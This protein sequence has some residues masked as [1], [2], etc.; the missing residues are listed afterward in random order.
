MEMI[1]A[2][3]HPPSILYRLP[4]MRMSPWLNLSHPTI[5]SGLMMCFSPLNASLSL[6]QLMFKNVLL[7]HLWV[8][9]LSVWMSVWMLYKCLF[10]SETVSKHRQVLSNGVRF[11]ISLILHWGQLKKGQ[12]IKRLVKMRSLSYRLVSFSRKRGENVSL[13]KKLM[14]MVIY[15]HLPPSLTAKTKEFKEYWYI[16]VDMV[17]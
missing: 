7:N 11:R 15:Q 9:S 1:C 17:A 14:N 6:T 16:C 10:S 12:F 5:R 2:G 8:S 13:E 4:L 3:V